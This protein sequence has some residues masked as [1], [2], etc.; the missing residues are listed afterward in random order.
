MESRGRDRWER[1]K[2]CRERRGE[3]EREREIWDTLRKT[4]MGGRERVRKEVEME[5]KASPIQYF[6]ILMW[7]TTD[8]MI[9]F[10]CFN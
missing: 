1:Q 7:D 6:Q 9:D 4:V 8:I 2:R 3:K 10:L 5:L